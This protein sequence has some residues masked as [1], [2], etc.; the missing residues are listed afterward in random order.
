MTGEMQT[1]NKSPLGQ[2]AWS[3]RMGMRRPRNG[4]GTQWQ[5]SSLGE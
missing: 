3:D 5:G 2:S 4:V 1:G